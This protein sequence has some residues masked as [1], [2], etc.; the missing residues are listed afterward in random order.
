MGEGFIKKGSNKMK[1]TFTFN[2]P[3]DIEDFKIYNQAVENYSTL[4]VIFNKCRQ[5]LKYEDYESF[6]PE[7]WETIIEE[8]RDLA[9][10]E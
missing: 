7:K 3:D 9:W 10:R 4:N 8:I 5:I 1:A 6:T 2:F